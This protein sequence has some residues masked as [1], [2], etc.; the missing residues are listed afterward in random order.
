MRAS[1]AAHSRLPHRTSSGR[2]GSPRVRFCIAR[3]SVREP[4]WKSLTSRTTRANP[5]ASLEGSSPTRLPPD[6]ARAEP[7]GGC[8]SAVGTLKPSGFP[9]RWRDPDS[10]RGHHNFQSCVAGFELDLQGLSSVSADFAA[11]AL[12]RTL[13]PFARRAADGVVRRPFRR[14]RLLDRCSGRT[15]PGQRSMW[16]TLDCS[17]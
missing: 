2:D 11:C 7:H 5:S 6:S 13:R 3:S 17:S 14:G 10:N 9:S 1:P 16:A 8:R 15:S 12:S 4:T